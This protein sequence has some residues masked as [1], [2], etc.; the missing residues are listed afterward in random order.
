MEALQEVYSKYKLMEQQI[1]RTKE[2][3]KVKIPEIQKAIEIVEL[4]EKQQGKFQVG[5]NF[6]KSFE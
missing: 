5:K 1:S 4:L 2:M 3:M 6:L